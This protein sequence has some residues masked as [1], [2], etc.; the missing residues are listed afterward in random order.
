MDRGNILHV[1]DLETSEQR[2]DAE[3]M[4]DA[5]AGSHCS[6]NAIAPSPLNPSK[7]FSTGKIGP[8]SMH[9]D[10]SAYAAG[11]IEAK[12]NSEQFKYDAGAFL[13][14]FSPLD[15]DFGVAMS[16]R[17][18]TSSGTERTGETN[19]IA[20]DGEAARVRDDLSDERAVDSAGGGGGFAYAAASSFNSRIFLKREPADSPSQSC[21]D[22]KA[23]AGKRGLL[24]RLGGHGAPESAGARLGPVIAMAAIQILGAVAI[25]LAALW[26][27]GCK[28]N[29]QKKAEQHDAAVHVQAEKGTKAANHARQQVA[30]AR[31][32]LASVILQVSDL[33]ASSQSKARLDQLLK[34]LGNAD[35]RL[36]LIDGDCEVVI[37]AF[38]GMVKKADA[39]KQDVYDAGDEGRQWYVMWGSICVGV[40][41]GALAFIL[42]YELFNETKIALAL[43]AGLIAGAFAFM[44]TGYVCELLLPVVKTAIYVGGGIVVVGGGVWA[45]RAVHEGGWM[46]A[47]HGGL[48]RAAARAMGNPVDPIAKGA[49][50]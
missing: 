20:G 18:G 44:F 23:P 27:C 49:A 13:T 32:D 50:A 48:G 38:G 17:Y 34:L 21:E 45:W 35:T 3:S 42:V 43:I 4:A 37:A 40:A 36:G 25:L 19:F 12:R 29:S 5:G 46:N 10:A 6:P 41:A 39:L 16:V 14:A 11:M 7:G 15:D 47:L 9:F 28:A 24:R 26:L 1:S 33:E 31:A 30:A 8:H 22:G 2:C